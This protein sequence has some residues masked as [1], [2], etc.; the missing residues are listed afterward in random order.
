MKD[1][2]Y[3]G[4]TGFCQKREKNKSGVWSCRGGTVPSRRDV[5][6]GGHEVVAVVAID[7]LGQQ[8]RQESKSNKGTPEL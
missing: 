3:V 6:V 7:H 8:L 1:P 5:D 4:R 2:R